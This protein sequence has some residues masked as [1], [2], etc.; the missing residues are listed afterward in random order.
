MDNIDIIRSLASF[1][2]RAKLVT[3]GSLYFGFSKIY[4]KSGSMSKHYKIRSHQSVIVTIV[5][6]MA[7]KQ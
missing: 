3:E 1:K 5:L 7:M 2:V 4:K 6:Y